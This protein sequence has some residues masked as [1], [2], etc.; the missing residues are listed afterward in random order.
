M[1]KL[2]NWFLNPKSYFLVAGIF[3]ILTICCVFGYVMYNNMLTLSI[4]D[5]IY[6]IL[7]W[8]LIGIII[9]LFFMELIAATLAIIE[10][11]LRYI[12]M[13]KTKRLKSKERKNTKV[14]Y[15]KIVV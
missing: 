15:D 12:Q 13:Q 2:K 8:G 5:I 14:P 3:A 6:N 4:A 9:G 11:M 10:Y 1:Q 7:V